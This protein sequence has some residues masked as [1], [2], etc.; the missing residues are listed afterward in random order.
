MEETHRMHLKRW[1][2]KWWYLTQGSYVQ[3]SGYVTTLYLDSIHLFS[4]GVKNQLTNN[5]GY[6]SL[7]LVVSLSY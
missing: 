1:L 5:F 6:V 4:S 7:D 2:L 3:Y